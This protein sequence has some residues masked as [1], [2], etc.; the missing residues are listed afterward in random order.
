MKPCWPTMR[1]ARERRAHAA[2]RRVG[3]G[4]V[5]DLGA[6]ALHRVLE[7]RDDVFRGDL[8]RARGAG[9]VVVEQLLLALDL[10]VHRAHGDGARDLARGVPAHAVGD[11][12]EARASCR[13]GSCPRCG[14][15]P[16]RRP[17]RRRSGW[18]RRASCTGHDAT[19][20]S[21]W[22]T[23]L[24]SASGERQAPMLAARGGSHSRQARTPHRMARHPA[25]RVVSH[26]RA[27]GGL[28]ARRR[29][30]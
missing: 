2:L 18:C 30:A 19:G 16:C 29:Q 21:G 12:E 5:V 9:D 4:L 22:N 28:R 10:L 11:D 1:M 6:G 23:A 14:R 3:A 13:R 8:V 7:E 27:P 26:R 17:W 15:G 20:A 25:L 24:L